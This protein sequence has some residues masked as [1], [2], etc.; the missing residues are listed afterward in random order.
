MKHS[1]LILGFLSFLTF[2]CNPQPTGLRIENKIVEASCGQCQFGLKAK[3]PGCDLAVRIDG[4]AYF[5]DGT[6]IDDHGDAHGPD[7]FCNRVRRA[8]VT[9]RIVKGR[10]FAE[11]FKLLP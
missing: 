11:S 8:L 2:A 10:F 3:K 9:G 6:R 7:G 5:V 4:K 1:L